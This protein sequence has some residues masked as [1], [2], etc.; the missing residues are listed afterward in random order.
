MDLKLLV[1]EVIYFDSFV[2]LFG[3]L[4]NYW[5]ILSDRYVRKR[6]FAGYFSAIFKHR[7]VY[8]SHSCLALDKT[9]I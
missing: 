4:Q 8:L 2:G 6:W 5:L 1:K 3:Q 7:S 9:E